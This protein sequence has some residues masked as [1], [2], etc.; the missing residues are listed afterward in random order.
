MCILMSMFWALLY[1]VTHFAKPMPNHL[2]LKTFSING[3]E[4]LQNY[5]FK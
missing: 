4:C 3:L 5:I 1:K 2:L